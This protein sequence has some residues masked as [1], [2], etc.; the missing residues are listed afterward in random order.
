MHDVHDMT[1]RTLQ[2][3]GRCLQPEL[4]SRCLLARSFPR[5]RTH[6]TCRRDGGSL[7]GD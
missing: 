1:P 3:A 5:L 6:T 2:L 4:E 7:T